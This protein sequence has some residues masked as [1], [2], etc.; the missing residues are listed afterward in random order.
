M[1]EPLLD[2]SPCKGHIV[3]SGLTREPGAITLLSP[4]KEHTRPILK[5]SYELHVLIQVELSIDEQCQ[6]AAI[7]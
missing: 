1:Q 6:A 7:Y 2:V 3:F 5:S 4:Q